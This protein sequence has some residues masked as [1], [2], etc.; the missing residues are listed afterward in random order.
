MEL[1]GMII[2]SE[3]V[4]ATDCLRPCHPGVTQLSPNPSPFIVRRRLSRLQ[5]IA[6]SSGAFGCG[7]H[8]D[9]PLTLQAVERYFPGLPDLKTIAIF[10]VSHREGGPP[11][12]ELPEEPADAFL[13]PAL[14]EGVG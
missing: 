3:P 4:Q 1:D 12:C 11:I 6:G 2:R 5:T 14:F 13:R 9:H 8:C 10:H 7:H